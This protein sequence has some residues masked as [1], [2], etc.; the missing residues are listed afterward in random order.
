[1]VSRIPPWVA[2]RGLLKL[3]GAEVVLGPQIQPRYCYYEVA[4]GPS[5]QPLSLKTI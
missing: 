1:M 2:V 5:V 4:R 3:K